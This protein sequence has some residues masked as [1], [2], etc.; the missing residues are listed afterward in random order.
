M[1]KPDTQ[2]ALTTLQNVVEL[3]E[4]PEDHRI[5]TDELLLIA[6]MVRLLQERKSGSVRHGLE[7]VATEIHA[8][9]AALRP[10]LEAA[11][12]P[13]IGDVYSGAVKEIDD[14]I[15]V[16][17]KRMRIIDETADPSVAYDLLIATG[18]R[19]H[20]T[21]EQWIADE[22]ERSMARHAENYLTGPL[23]HRRAK[24]KGLFTRFV[25][26]SGKLGKESNA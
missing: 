20:L 17:K 9:T 10:S 8:I 4:T 3:Y 1:H 22:Y 24:I 23:E 16:L 14:Q 6:D 7:S 11:M 26:K 2:P 12:G 15:E 18:W 25:S 19:T 13:A 21:K 5:V